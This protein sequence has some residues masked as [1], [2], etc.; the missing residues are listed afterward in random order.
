MKLNK[1][2]QGA[3]LNGMV[4]QN[5]SSLNV[6]KFNFVVESVTE[7][8]FFSAIDPFLPAPAPPQTFTALLSISTGY[9]YM[10]ISS[11]VNLFLKN[12]FS[13][14]SFQIYFYIN[15]MMII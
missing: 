13:P 3:L 14:S 2:T 12:S 7:V 15:N 11:L 5:K 4:Y 10:D 6:F 9:E 1:Y 8:L